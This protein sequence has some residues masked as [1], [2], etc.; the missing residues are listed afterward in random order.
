MGPRALAVGARR[1]DGNLGRDQGERLGEDGRPRRPV[2]ARPAGRGHR[3]EAHPPLDRDGRHPGGEVHQVANDPA[4]VG[5]ATGTTTHG[6]RL[7][8]LAGIGRGQPAHAAGLY[9][10]KMKGLT[11]V[12]GARFDLLEPGGPQ[13]GDDLA[14]QGGSGTGRS[15]PPASASRRTRHHPHG[16]RLRNRSGRAEADHVAER[17]HPDPPPLRLG[18]V[19]REH[20]SGPRPEGTQYTSS[21]T[22][23]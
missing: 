14:G 3:A 20:E 13:F 18:H 2:G 22:R 11:G 1:R 5:T 7:T 10:R 4:A 8:R 23:S 12:T 6:G 19:D 15:R 21:S 17:E 9:A 16:A